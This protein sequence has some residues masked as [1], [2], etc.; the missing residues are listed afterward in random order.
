MNTQEVSK[1]SSGNPKPVILVVEDDKF[2][3][4]LIVR[5]LQKEDFD[6]EAAIEATEAFK[7][8]EGKKPDLILLDLVLPGMDG[9]QITSHLKKNPE[10]A[11]IP[12]VI[13]SNLGQ[14]E[15]IERAKDCGAIDY[16]VKANFTPGEI[17]EK[18]RQILSGR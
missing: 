8:I 5:K 15:D 1:K 17:V 2:L 13:L 12:I 18:V 14:K 7:L 6:T 4:E 11:N 3:R 9:F 16:M 10:T